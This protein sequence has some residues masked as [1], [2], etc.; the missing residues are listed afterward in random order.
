MNF[1]KGVYVVFLR[2]WVHNL[3]LLL[4]LP[5]PP[6]KNPPNFCIPISFSLDFFTIFSNMLKNVFSNTVIIWIPG[7]LIKM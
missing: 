7:N 6:Q 4:P 5:P 1:E 3:G 2:D